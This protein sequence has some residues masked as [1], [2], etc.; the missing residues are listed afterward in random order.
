MRVSLR[1]YPSAVDDV[2]ESPNTL[3]EKSKVMSYRL[4]KGRRMAKDVRRIVLERRR[5]VRSH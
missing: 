2:K 3:A 1:V 4:K 5:S